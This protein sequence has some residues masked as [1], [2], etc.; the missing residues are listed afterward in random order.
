MMAI[1]PLFQYVGILGHPPQTLMPLRSLVSVHGLPSRTCVDTHMLADWRYWAIKRLS[2]PA[3]RSNRKFTTRHHDATQ[4]L[5]R[6]ST[7]YN[8]HSC[9]PPR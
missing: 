4:A 8:L 2:S 3:P 7:T 9:A 5:Q 1:G 6:M